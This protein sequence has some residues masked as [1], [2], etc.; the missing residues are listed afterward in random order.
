MRRL[1]SVLLMSSIAAAAEVPS[2]PAPPSAGTAVDGPIRPGMLRIVPVDHGE[3]Y[4][5]WVRRGRERW[6]QGRPTEAEEAFRRALAAVPDGT[7]A[8]LGLAAL[9]LERRRPERARRLYRRVLVHHPGHPLALAGL[10]LVAGRERPRL[11]AA[12]EHL[13][14]RHREQAP[15]HYA[16]AN[17]YAQEGDWRRAQRRYFEA[18]RLDPDQPDYAYDLAVSLDHL[19]K[20]RLAAGFYRKALQLARVRRP[21]FDPAVVSRRLAQLEEALP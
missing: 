14:R 7:E 17:L 12:L 15:L 21:R 6:R 11:R 4:A 18:F 1:V 9:A 19:G 13:L 16:L 10:A 5:C 8:L 20:Y 3:V 2:C